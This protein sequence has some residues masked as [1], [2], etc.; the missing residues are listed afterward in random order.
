[1]LL[2]E[3]VEFLLE[4]NLQ[5]CLHFGCGSF[6]NSVD[7]FYKDL[8]AAGDETN[9]VSICTHLGEITHMHFKRIEPVKLQN[10]VVF[11]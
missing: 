4:A 8:S 5:Y 6:A 10:P 1:M 9:D 7:I 2:Q 3:I 11:V